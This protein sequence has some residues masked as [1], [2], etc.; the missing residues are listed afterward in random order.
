MPTD[1]KVPYL[2]PKCHASAFNCPHCHAYAKQHWGSVGIFVGANLQGWM[3]N[4]EMCTCDHCHQHCFWRYEKLIFPDVA[5]VQLPNFDL[6]EDVKSDYMEAASILARSPR[7]A[8]ALLRLTI[9]KICKS[10]GEPGKNI[11]DDIASLVKKGLPV[12]VQQALDV[13]RVV[14]NNAVHPGQIDLKDDLDS[15]TKLFDL[16]NIIGDVMI[17]QP[18]L[19]QEIYE[20][21]LPKSQ[22]DAIKKRDG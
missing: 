9:Q 2:P 10:L 22:R 13:V 20:S 14:G 3:E 4:T 1:P 6:P 18:K 5:I 12:Q 21:V 7:G 15:A 17:T 16:V 11:N 19:V 8:A